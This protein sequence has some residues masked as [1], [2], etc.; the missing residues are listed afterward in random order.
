MTKQHNILFIGGTGKTGR[1]VVEGLQQH[2]Q[3]VQ[4]GISGKRISRIWLSSEKSLSTCSVRNPLT[5][6]SLGKECGLEQTSHSE[7]K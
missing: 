3:I 6:P 2:N 5:N 7:V 4:V 1:K